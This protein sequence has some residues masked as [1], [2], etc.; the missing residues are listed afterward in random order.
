MVVLFTDAYMSFGLNE[1][2]L[3]FRIEPGA[4]D[5]EDTVL[6]YFICYLSQAKQQTILIE[7]HIFNH[8]TYII[9]TTLYPYG[10]T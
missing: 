10:D 5:R 8:N 2:N 7:K 9:L 4:S 1:L 6:Q 3:I